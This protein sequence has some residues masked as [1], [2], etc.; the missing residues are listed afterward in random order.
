EQQ[1]TAEQPE[2]EPSLTEHRALR[3]FQQEN[4]PLASQTAMMTK[5]ERNAVVR[6]KR[7]RLQ[8]R[9]DQLVRERAEANER[10]E[11]LQQE[12]TRTSRP[13]AEET[14][15]IHHQAS[16]SAIAQAGVLPPGQEVGQEQE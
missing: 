4:T 14:E 10:A 11:K 12:L 13:P 3:S 1:P 9:I 8:T 16:D 2:L 5:P 6:E 7:V 15:E